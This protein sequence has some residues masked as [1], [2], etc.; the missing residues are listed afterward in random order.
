[1]KRPHIH[2]P[3]HRGL[4]LVAGLKILKGLALLAVGVGALRLLHQDVAAFAERL[5]EAIRIDPHHHFVSHLLD[6]LEVVDD[7]RLKIISLISFGYAGL[8]LTEGVGLFLEKRWAEYLTIVVTASLIP[9]EIYELVQHLSPL[10]IVA[11]VT[12]VAVVIYLVVIVRQDRRH[13]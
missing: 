7:H 5:V 12:N 3:H 1:V 6:K 13:A 4:W 2:P 8:L 9:L 11:L 10:K